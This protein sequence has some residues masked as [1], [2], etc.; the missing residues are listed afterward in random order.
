[1]VDG[2]LKVA[3]P[4]RC[5][6]EPHGSREVSNTSAAFE[7]G[8]VRFPARGVATEPPHQLTAAVFF[9]LC[10]SVCGRS[11]DAAA[12]PPR[13]AALR[14]KAQPAWLVQ[15]Y[16]AAPF[17]VGGRKFDIR[18]LVVITPQYHVLWYNKWILRMCSEE[19][20]ADDLH[21]QVKH[22]SNH[23]VQ[24]S[25]AAYGCVPSPDTVGQSGHVTA[26]V[27]A[28]SAHQVCTHMGR[29]GRSVTSQQVRRRQRAL[30]RRLSTVHHQSPAIVC[31]ARLG[32]VRLALSSGGLDVG[33][34]RYLNDTEGSEQAAATLAHCVD[35]M[36]RIAL[37]TT[38][39]VREV[40]T[41]GPYGW[42]SYE[43]R[44]CWAEVWKERAHRGRVGRTTS[45][46]RCWG[47]T[48]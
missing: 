28:S 42:L 46:F 40:R 39:A 29:C 41:S 13:R 35:Q 2:A 1:M 23:C 25:S 21:N 30:H 11:D 33:G 44:Q 16:V 9:L 12:A 18:A 48:S 24:T 38:E 8:G 19:Y 4:P 7:R 10:V 5:A 45:H 22:I 14:P 43:R 37:H 32:R 3:E 34:R 31:L 36:K 26:C 47:M 6:C 27:A 17:L 20:T 15:R